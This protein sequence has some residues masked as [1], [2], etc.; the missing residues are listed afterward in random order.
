MNPIE[1]PKTFVF[2]PP[3]YGKPDPKQLKPIGIDTR[4]RV[5]QRGSKDNTCSFAAYNL[6][7]E[8][9][10]AP[11]THDLPERKFEQ[12]ASTLRKALSA[13]DRT[14]PDI[15][16]QLNND[17]IKR[18]LARFT[19]VT[20]QEP[21]TLLLLNSIELQCT[22]EVSISTILPAFL[23]QKQFKN[24][25]E[26]IYY[27][28]I[29]KRQDLFNEFFTKL[30]VD[31][32][33][34]F[35]N[36][37]NKDPTLYRVFCEGKNWDQLFWQKKCILLDNYAKQLCASHYNM[38]TSSWHPN[39]PIE[40]LI[41]ELQKRGPLLVQGT[42]GAQHY[43]V[44]PRKFQ[45]QIANRDVYGWFK[46]DPKNTNHV[47]GHAI[48][49]VG[50]EKTLKNQIVYYIDP[51]DESDPLDAKKQKIYCLSYT[52]LTSFGVICDSHGFIRNDAPETIGYALYYK[53]PELIQQ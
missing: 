9:Y 18:F 51:D 4:S 37:K 13:H 40:K 11:N 38:C 43:K 49:L 12:I 36:A 19:H 20:L 6:L 10:K 50:A 7:R 31:A 23:E 34:L 24:L 15:A 2:C 16:N 53:K 33:T 5:I 14:L 8:R 41:I 3:T 47:V 17:T 32:A 27:L 25:Y 26:Y 44:P 21:E 46:E 48:I 30:N 35:E 45:K 52:K 29:G 1:S 22:P 28:K 39:Q 42:F